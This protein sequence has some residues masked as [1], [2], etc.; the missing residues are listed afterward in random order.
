MDY[1]KDFQI[2]IDSLMSSL[3]E[4]LAVLRT[5]R[6]TPRLIENIPVSYLGQEMQVK[7]LGS[8]TVELPRDLVVTLW[9]KGAI[10]SVVKAIES[11]N[12]GVGVSNY[13]NAVRVKLPELTKERREELGKIVKVAAE[14]VRI[15]MRV[16]R[17]TIHKKIN[18]E[19]DEDKKFKLKNELQE[20]VD[21]FNKTIDELIENKIKEISVQ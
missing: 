21:K 12:L 16:E 7:Q 2:K 18:T 3:K 19:A 8:I 6:P 9:D 1:L 10:A 15:K 17:D 5:N 4:E 20:K 14:E 13:E 11:A